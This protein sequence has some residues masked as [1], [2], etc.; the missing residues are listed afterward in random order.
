MWSTLV[1]N[2]SF[3][4]SGRGLTR[5]SEALKGKIT[6][7]APRTAPAKSNFSVRIV[8]WENHLQKGE[9][10]SGFCVRRNQQLTDLQR[11]CGLNVN[12]PT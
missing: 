9:L 12:C 7:S 5:N 2:R 6:D 4:T 10:A 11:G 8:A 3:K 1:L